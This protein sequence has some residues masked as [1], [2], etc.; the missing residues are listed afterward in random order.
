MTYQVKSITS[1]R[2]A[3]QQVAFA[4]A[5]PAN[6]VPPRT[7]VNTATTGKYIGNNMVCTR[8]GAGSLSINGRLA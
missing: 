1:A 6:L 2:N 8:P 4:A 5:K 7:I 3:A